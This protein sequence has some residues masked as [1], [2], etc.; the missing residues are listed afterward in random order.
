[1]NDF[2][3]LLL[4]WQETPNDQISD[5]FVYGILFSFFIW[6]V[7][8]LLKTIRRASLVSNL[9]NQVSQ[10][11]K[12]A[13]PEILPHLKTAFD[14]NSELAEVW[15]EFQNSLITREPKENQAKIVY[16]TD[17]ASLF[18]SE[19]RLLGQHMNLRFWNSVSAL[20]VGL[21][22][23]GTFV[24]LVWGLRSFSGI[25][26]FTSDEIREA[27]K[28]LLPGVSTAFVTSV[29]GM[30][31]S[32]LFNGLE[33]WRINRINRAIAELQHAL[34]QLFTLTM[35]EEIAFRQEDELK[36]QTAALKSF[37]TDLANDIKRAMDSIISEARAQDAQTNQEIIQELQ[38][39]PTAI[40][41]TLAEK[42]A[43]NLNNLNITVEELQRQS[44]RLDAL[45]Q[46]LLESINQNTQDS[47]EI[48]QELRNV[49]T[50][51]NQI[52]ELHFNHLNT[53]I[54]NL[55]TT[56]MESKNDIQ[57]EMEHGRQEILGEFHRVRN[58]LSNAMAEK[59]MPSLT[60]LGTIVSDIQNVA[61]QNNQEVVQELHKVSL[62]MSQIEI[63]ARMVG[64]AIE[65]AI[66]LPEHVAQIA[67]DTQELL[68]ST[69]NQ[70]GEGFSQWLTDMDE[71]LQ[72]SAQ[73]LQDIQQNTIALLQL[74][75]EQIETINSQL[76]NSRA[77]LGSGRNMLQQMNESIKNIHEINEEN[78]KYF[79]SN[80]E[81][82][83]QI[84]NALLKSQ[85]LLNNSA[86]R[87]Q[88]IDN[89]LQSIFAEIE[90]GLN[91]Y[92]TSTRVSLNTYLKDFS[93]QFK[94]ALEALSGTVEILEDTIEDLKNTSKGKR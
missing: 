52:M 87:F 67:N 7:F 26:D 38:N 11:A 10:H 30:L 29:W 37:S 21:G 13:K 3:T 78:Q 88:T 44:E 5:I 54:E 49:P 16:K 8:F 40:S 6:V 27:I 34:D 79:V 57:T 83:Q 4:P 28:E 31:T 45:H 56:L 94:R 42:L 22:I 46:S 1:M 47:Q 50:A 36:Q 74:Q 75:G 12:P 70:T 59:L 2:F 9:V 86:Q 72:R 35:P 60:N 91:T 80:R 89:G 66:N 17:E 62:S 41:D 19:E 69:S 18:F 53:T 90:K 39:T 25:N 43:P 55:S 51:I 58:S 93:N 15:H 65:N 61:E 24:G 68:K 85:Q 64:R 33:K 84:Q 63:F 92:A 32:L 76:V 82:M 71:F 77:I 14:C 73:T 20:L 23:L 48:T 81:A